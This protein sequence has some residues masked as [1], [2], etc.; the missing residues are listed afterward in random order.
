[1]ANCWSY[2]LAAILHC[3]QAWVYAGSDNLWAAL[4]NEL[5]KGV[6]RDFGE[7]PV[8]LYMNGKH[9]QIV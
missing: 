1:M 8:R 5:I 9:R 2:C 4:V 6:E 7:E 3:M